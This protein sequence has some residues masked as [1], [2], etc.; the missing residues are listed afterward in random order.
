MSIVLEERPL[1][2]HLSSQAY[3]LTWQYG[4]KVAG[5][6]DLVCLER[7]HT[8]GMT[9]LQKPFHGHYTV[10]C[11]NQH[12]QLRTGGYC[13]SKVLLPTHPSWWQVA[14][15]DYGKDARVLNSESIPLGLERKIKGQLVKWC[16]AEMPVNTTLCMA[17]FSKLTPHQPGF[18]KGLP[19]QKFRH[20]LCGM[21]LQAVCWCCH[22]TNSMKALKGFKPTIHHVQ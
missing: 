10:T 9:T 1:N 22:P 15:S 17:C 12:P 2:G 5:E 18:S 16:S 7:L 19:Y 13:W 20:C 21:F 8:S 11:A 4:V 14:H 3:F 6:K